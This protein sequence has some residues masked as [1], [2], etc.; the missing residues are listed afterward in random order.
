MKTILVPTDFSYCALQALRTA[1]QLA[2][3]T[4]A[5]IV[6][7]HNVFTE[8]KWESLP[9][10]RRV[11]YPETLSKIK[12][13][14]NRMNLLVASGLLRNSTVSNV[15]TY[16][17]ATEEIVK[18][19]KTMKA[20]L[21]VMGSH[22]NEVSDRYFIGSTVQKVMREAP[23]PVMT[24]QNN[25]KPGNWKKLVF[26]TDFYKDI[27]KPFEKIRKIA[28]ELNAVVYL[29]FV[30][31]PTDF[32][33]TRSINRLMDSFIA[34]YPDLKFK[35]VIY[36]HVEAAEGILQFVEDYPMDWIALITRWHATKPQYVIG[37]T[38]TLAF[39]SEIPVLSVNILPTPVK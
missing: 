23:C 16:G 18:K 38:E 9:T 19:A 15:I 34:R 25:Y 35:K 5:K 13:A 1:V 11:D 3:T 31:R 39:R 17:T 14:E 10:M 24:I 4:G 30:N 36:N 8:T 22:G 28:I 26:A 2:R 12:D 29:L 27:Y 6:I 20:D 32:K 21:I 33:D 7:V 37:H